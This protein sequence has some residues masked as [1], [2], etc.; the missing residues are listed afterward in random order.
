MPQKELQTKPKTLFN[1]LKM[2]IL[3]NMVFNNFSGLVVQT[4]KKQTVT[5]SVIEVIGL[6]KKGGKKKFVNSW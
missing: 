2:I 4:A 3:P 1:R 6:P 5:F